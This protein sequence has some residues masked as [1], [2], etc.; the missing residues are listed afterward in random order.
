[1]KKIQK[2][3]Q[4]EIEW[5]IMTDLK[6]RDGWEIDLCTLTNKKKDYEL[7]CYGDA[8]LINDLFRIGDMVS[9][10]QLFK[11]S[12]FNARRVKKIIAEEEL[13]REYKK[14]HDFICKIEDEYNGN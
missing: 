5:I 11:M 3:M 7:S 2:E 9:R 6:R 12:F 10:H 13:L 4:K 1:M 14:L 8:V